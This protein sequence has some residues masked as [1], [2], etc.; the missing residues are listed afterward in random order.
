MTLCISYNYNKDDNN[1]DDK[2]DNNNKVYRWLSRIIILKI[3][4]F[5]VHTHHNDILS[6][7]TGKITVKIT[8]INIHSSWSWSWSLPES[9]R[10][11]SKWELGSQ[12]KVITFYIPK[13]TS[14]HYWW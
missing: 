12:Q 10:N 1:K 6:K 7:R 8:A 11:M 5:F 4:S 2:V 3:Y 14:W 9:E 13:S